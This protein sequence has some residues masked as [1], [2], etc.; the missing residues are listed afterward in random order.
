MAEEY[1]LLMSLI[2]PVISIGLALS[3]FLRTNKHD[4]AKQAAKI[5]E[6]E[7]KLSTVSQVANTFTMGELA[8]LK[9]SVE[10]LKYRV[11]K[12]DG[13]VEKKIDN[14]TTQVSEMNATM[15]KILNSVIQQ[16]KT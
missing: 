9:Q 6:I 12:L 10:D 7:Q 14:L 8:A 5:S 1:T 15:Q 2:I 11:S 13:D 3:A 16:L 4:A